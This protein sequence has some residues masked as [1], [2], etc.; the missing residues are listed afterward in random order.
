MNDSMDRSA[1][2]P[3][4]AMRVARRALIL[5]A[6]V[7]RGSIDSSAGQP[8][9]ESLHKR[10]LDWL[11]TL[12]LWDDVELREERALRAALGTLDEKEVIRITWYAEGL[13]VLAWAL[14]RLDLPQHDEKVD[15]YAVADSVSFLSED[16]A[17][18]IGAAS[19]RS[20][21]G[22]N[23]CQELL[24]AIHSKRTRE[25]WG[26]AV[27]PAATR[28]WPTI[29]KR[30]RSPAPKPATASAARSAHDDRRPGPTAPRWSKR[31]RS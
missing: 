23:A 19:L 3:V 1:E 13:A 16:A 12:S 9:A 22:L 24:Y 29:T 5:S 4:S 20:P 21:A 7:C 6:V 10:I 15:A 26:R 18:V 8:E 17:D 30:P 2:T 28:W 25:K 14:N 31:G 27:C 11:T